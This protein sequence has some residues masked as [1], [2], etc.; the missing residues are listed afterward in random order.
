MPN[1]VNPLSTETYQERVLPREEDVRGPYF[2][3]QTAVLHSLPFRRM[4]H[5]AQVFFS[6]NNDHVCTRIEHSLHVATIAET[7]AR[8]LGLNGELA[9]AIGLGH[10]LGHAPFGHAGE[11]VLSNQAGEAGGFIHE[12]H[13]LRVA[14]ILGNRGKGLNL[15][16]GVRDGIVCHCG[17]APDREVEPRKDKID[18]A[19][20]KRR[21]NRPCSYEGCIARMSDR[22]AYLGRDLEDAIYGGFVK[23]S[24]VPPE[25]GQVLGTNNGEIID[26]LVIDIIETSKTTGKISLSEERYS[27][28]MALYQFSAECIYKHPA[29]ERYKLY[30]ARIIERLF[31]YLME[32]LSVKGWITEAYE[33]SPV[34]LD[35]RFGRFLKGMIDVYGDGKEPNIVVVRDYVAGMTDGYALRCMREI[36]LPDELSFDP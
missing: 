31:E 6:P 22:V 29:I 18:L 26:A 17:E 24:D 12:V 36:S 13:G 34:P 19:G 8:A 30:C 14:D 21:D 4:K 7:I 10:D 23:M 28:L 20:I 2:R 32:L 33:A 5:K 11:T 35:K 1:F 3:D 25:V 9:Y 27:V 16:Y 15:T